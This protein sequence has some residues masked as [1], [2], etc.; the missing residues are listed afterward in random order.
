MECK[1]IALMEMQV[2]DSQALVRAALSGSKTPVA[3]MLRCCAERLN[4]F[5]CVLWEASPLAD[6]KATPPQGHLYSVDSWFPVENEVFAMHNL[7]LQASASGQVVWRN[8]PACGRQ[9]QLQGDIIDH[10]FLRRHQ[11]G[12]LCSVPVPLVRGQMGALSLYRKAREADFTTEHENRLRQIAEIFAPLYQAASDKISLELLNKVDQ[13]IQRA[14][15]GAGDAP[16]SKPAKQEVLAKICEQVAEALLCAEVSLF[17][18]DRLIEPEVF[19]LQ[20]TTMRDGLIGKKKLRGRHEE[21]LTGWVL[22]EQKEVHI[23]NILMYWEDREEIWK[24]YPGLNWKD[25]AH[26][27]QAAKAKYEHIPPGEI[28]PQSLMAVPIHAG[29]KL[30]GVIRCTSLLGGSSYF[31]TRELKLLNLIAAQIGLCWSNWLGRRELQHENDVWQKV[32]ECVGHLNQFIA[33]ELKSPQPQEQRIF[34]E[35][36][37]AIRTYILPA[38]TSV[39]I[40]LKDEGGKFLC[41]M[42]STAIAANDTERQ[43]SVRLLQRKYPTSEQPPRSAITEVFQKRSAISVATLADAANYPADMSPFDRHRIVVP[44]SVGENIYGVLDI[45]RTRSPVFPNNVLLAAQLLGQ[46]LGLYHYL[47]LTVGRLQSAESKASMALGDL[48]KLQHLQTQTFQDLAHQM[49]MPVIQAQARIELA[50]K[51]LSGEENREMVLPVRGLFR[52]VGRV[53]ESVRVLADVGMGK[54]VKVKPTSLDMDWL[55]K[56]LIESAVD[57]ELTIEDYR[58][59]RFNVR[60]DGFRL[61]PEERAIVDERLLEQAINNIFDNAAKYSYSHTE[62]EVYGGLTGTGRFQVAVKNK[63]LYLSSDSARRCRQRGWR[64]P[65]AESITG[66]GSGIGLW[67]VDQVIA[68]MGG[69]LQAIP[70]N[71]EGITEFKLLFPVHR[72]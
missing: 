32:E 16:L 71:P 67:V 48:K 65:E 7:S 13:I 45:R 19:E 6:L 8:K 37:S 21:G 17:M 52:K 28:P 11:V 50:V 31:C 2:D 5:G 41:P 25:S 29:K 51:N 34:I 49:K 44:I 36:I 55:T 70:T 63:G 33:E 61:S 59:I 43:R 18:E 20:A 58:G 9:G 42:D 68:A 60:R 3:D 22:A 40:F 69:E 72:K 1:R 53:V 54:P 26:M 35:A 46:Q 24:R 27:V 38:A 64:S 47:V 23:F 30:L 12:Q 57:T 39:D 62:V 66:E 15:E 10:P 14:E 4:A 56:L